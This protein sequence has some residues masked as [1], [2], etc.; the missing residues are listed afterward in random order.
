MVVAEST[1]STHVS[2]KA[3]VDLGWGRGEGG[4]VGIGS[5]Y[6]GSA[7]WAYQR[8][9]LGDQAQM[10]K[11]RMPP[12]TGQTFFIHWVMQFVFRTLICRTVIYPVDCIIHFLNKQE[13]LR[14]FCLVESGNNKQHM[15]QLL[16]CINR[17]SSQYFSYRDAT[18]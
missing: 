8:D 9:W 4:W 3:L 18:Y 12:F 11:R 16:V 13:H 5:P 6:V 1:I 17:L 2:R 14:I 10:M 15:M 7:W